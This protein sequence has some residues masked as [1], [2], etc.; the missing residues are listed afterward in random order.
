[1]RRT[2]FKSIRHGLFA[3][4]AGFTVLLCVGYT[5]L[6]L[7][8]SYVT[9][10]MLV[11]RLLEREAAAVT[12]QFRSGGDIQSTGND[13]IRVYRDAGA[14]PPVVRAQVTAG[15]EHG[16]IF[17]DTGQH[18]H[19]RTLDLQAADG[20]RRLYLLADAGPLLVVS[21]LFQDVGGVLVAV[22]LGLIALALLLAYLLS[23]RLVL[24][25]QV[26]ADEI[27]SLAPEGS[28]NFSARQR[29]D[30]IGYLADKLGTTIAAL[31]AALH[32]EQAFTRDVGHE[33]RTP[34]TVMNNVLGQAASRPLQAHELSQLRAGLGELGGTV[35]VL[36]ALARAEHIPNET[37]DLRG[38][39]EDSLLRLL[40]QADWDNERLALQLPDRLEVTG[41]RHLS[42]LLLNNCLGNA[43]FHGGAGS[44]LRLSF[45]DGVLSLANTIDP[46][47]AGTMQGFLHGQHLLRRIA[48]AMGWEIAFHAEA[49]AYRVDI[50]PL[51][52][53]HPR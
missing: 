31:H 7:I 19:L 42:M 51:V 23:R 5:G 45:A 26:L 37:V 47:R 32:R 33:L 34:L 6:A 40:E 43:L 1:M 12:A 48:K 50:V 2:V 9:E 49:A 52:P 30:E 53:P 10:D 16:E 22:A 38:C 27:K 8:I 25:L 11:D 21:K 15:R 41:N 4:L 29:R 39:I 18:Y 24:P 17:T 46:D 44:R 35:D 13:L 3:A 36:F 20:R 28:T 14:L